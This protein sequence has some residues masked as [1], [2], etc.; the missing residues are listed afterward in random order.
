M[1]EAHPAETGKA[2]ALQSLT[3]IGDQ[4]LNRLVTVARMCTTL[5]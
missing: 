1:W 4:E 3:T 2:V 5:P